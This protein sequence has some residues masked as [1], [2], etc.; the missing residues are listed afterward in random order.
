MPLTPVRSF[1]LIGCVAVLATAAFGQAIRTTF[2]SYNFEN[3]IDFASFYGD[4]SGNG[5]V[6]TD[7]QFLDPA[8]YTSLNLAG[9]GGSYAFA[10]AGFADS[11][12]N[13]GLSQ[14]TN[15]GFEFLFK[16]PGSN[17]SLQAVNMLS[18]GNPGS[19]GMAI[20][21]DPTTD[22]ITAR[23]NGGAVVA[24][25]TYDA[26]AWNSAALVNDGILTT[27]YINS[28]AVGSVA[29]NPSTADNGW[30]MFVN[31][32]G[33]VKYTGF[34]DNVNAFTYTGTFTA[35][36]ISAIPE[37]STYP[38]MLGLGALGLVAWRRRGL[39]TN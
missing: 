34:V 14:A 33:S 19:N 13:G 11:P 22:R 17:D 31:P 4:S 10:G 32:G 7:G 6:M 30:H 25:A 9:A 23:I 29:A 12:L 36:N 18:V 28:V 1:C 27:L 8:S 39:R 21:Y 16:N 15:W 20:L 2:A 35:A 26:N 24:S 5:H 37:P 38:A 3:V